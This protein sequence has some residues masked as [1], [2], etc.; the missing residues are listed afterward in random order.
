MSYLTQGLLVGRSAIVTGGGSGIGKAIA[1]ELLSLG[2]KVLIA[3][4]DEA[5]LE[6]AAAELRAEMEVSSESES[7]SRGAV[8]TLACNI[9]DEDS[10]ERMVGSALESFGGL[11]YLVNNGGG[12]FPSPAKEITSKGWN[13][14]I[15][16]NLTGTFA[17][18]RAAFAQHFEAHG[19]AIVNIT[20]DH[21]SGFPG[22]AHTGA[23]RA[24]VDN[25]TKTLAVEWASSGVRVN[26]VAPGVIFSP[27]AA[28]NYALSNPTLFDDAVEAIPARRCGT[29]EEVS[30]A[31][32][33][34]LSPAASFVSGATLR[35]DAASSLKTHGFVRVP[36]HDRWPAP[37]PAPRL[38]AA[39]PRGSAPTE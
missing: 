7:E 34:L 35:V 13:A 4:R 26:A 19:G 38:A 9:R 33:W 31:A 11:D 15:D 30:A 32:V 29:P 12:Q 39:P 21:F 3:S 10:V 5:K 22:M 6:G 18:S 36:H 24:A 20:C 8:V 17:V 16:T 23:A 14:V 27:T 28:A 37:P 1:R 25:L 2:C